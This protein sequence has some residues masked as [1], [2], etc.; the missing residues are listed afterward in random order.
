MT[1]P[2]CSKKVDNL[3]YHV[4]LYFRY[5]NFCRVHQTLRVTL[6]MEARLSDHVL[7]VEEILSILDSKERGADAA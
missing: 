4:A 2:P 6:P 7:E 3:D 1:P 5:D